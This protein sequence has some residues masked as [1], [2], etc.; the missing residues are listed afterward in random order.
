MAGRSLHAAGAAE[1]VS[2]GLLISIEMGLVLVLVV[3]FGV[4][5]LYKLRRDKRK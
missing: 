2:S 1:T 4:W 5:E 3:G